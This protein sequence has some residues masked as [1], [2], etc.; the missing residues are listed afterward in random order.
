[1]AITALVA[2]AF[3]I[4]SLILAKVFLGLAFAFGL[5]AFFALLCVIISFSPSHDDPDDPGP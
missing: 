4:L 2:L 5:L 1:M 3:V